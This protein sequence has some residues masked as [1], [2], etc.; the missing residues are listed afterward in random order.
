LWAYYGIQTYAFEKQVTSLQEEKG[1]LITENSS[2]K[3][4]IVNLK[5]AALQ[6]NKAIDELVSAQVARE[7]AAALELAK[8]KQFGETWRKKFDNVLSAPA[9]VDQCKSLNERID[10]Y[11]EL[12]IVQSKEKP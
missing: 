12:R 9:S 2:M 3:T 6:Q 7:N 5:D 10:Q 1:R 8:A 11:I 4:Q